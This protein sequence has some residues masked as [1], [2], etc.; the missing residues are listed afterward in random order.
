MALPVRL[1]T[2]ALR[3][4]RCTRDGPCA[5]LPSACG[6]IGK[7]NR[8]RT[9][10]WSLRGS[11]PEPLDDGF[12]ALKKAGPPRGSNPDRSIRSRVLSPDRARR[13]QTAPRHAAAGPG[14]YS[15]V[16]LDWAAFQRDSNPLPI[17]VK[18]LALPMSYGTPVVNERVELSTS[19]VAARA[20]PLSEITRHP[21]P[22]RRG[23]RRT[24]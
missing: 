3:A 15:S 9:G 13:A 12:R 8:I 11:R 22:P 7:P 14:Y 2:L 5:D 4:D 17:D 18:S 20:L 10:V 21:P 1:D 23:I 16:S 19:G 24:N 6:A